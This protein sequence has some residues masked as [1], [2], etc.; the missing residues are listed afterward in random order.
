MSNDKTRSS[1]DKTG[2]QKHWCPALPAAILQA[3]N[4][5]GGPTA[6]SKGLD[7]PCSDS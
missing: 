3:G 4:L 5:A 6:E 2:S 1:T 7:F